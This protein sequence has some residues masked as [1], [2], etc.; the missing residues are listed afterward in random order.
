MKVISLK[1]PY[2]SLI[3]NGIKKIETR[4]WKTNYRGK[5]YIH[6]SVSKISKEILSNKEL[7]ELVDINNLSFGNIIC[8]CD[9]VDCIPMT[10]EFILKVKKN[11]RE[12]LSGEYA[13]GRYAWILE[14]VQVL[15][16]MIPAKG[17]LGIWNYNL[18]E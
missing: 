5:L 14:N 6:A 15:D 3:M 2:A 17:Q 7:M 8:S 18:E 12:F 4:S 10:D 11:R 9:L 16:Q 13:V 1:E